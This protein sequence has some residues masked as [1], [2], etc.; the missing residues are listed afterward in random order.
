MMQKP[1]LPI[2]HL[3]PAGYYQRQPL[4]RP[5][6]PPTLAED[7]FIHCT[8]GAEK[9]VEIANIYFA[10]LRDDLLALEVDPTRLTA[11]LRFEPPIAPAQTIA[12]PPHRAAVEQDTLFPHIYDLLD[13]QAIVNCITLQRGP[14]G[15]WYMP[16]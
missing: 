2:Y 3:T 7:G 16:D 10:D 5:Y 14:N 9:L 15:R 13:R 4:D 12:S 8:A 1:A 11:P 6:Q